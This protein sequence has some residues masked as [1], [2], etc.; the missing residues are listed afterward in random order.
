MQLLFLVTNDLTYDQRM[1]RICSTLADAGYEVQLIGRILPKSKPLARASFAQYRLR[2]FFNKGKLFYIEYNLR[3]FWY[4]LF[5]RF[6]LV[7]AV[8]LDTILPAYWLAK[9]RQKKIVYDAHEYFTEVPEV[10]HRPLTKRIWELVAQWTIPNIKHCYTVGE[11]LARLLSER[12][13][14]DFVVIRNCPKSITPPHHKAA[15]ENSVLLYQGALNMGRGI[16]A[17]IASMQ[18]VE[19]AILWLAGEGDLSEALRDLTKKM[20]VTN[21]V[22]FLGRISP[23]ELKDLTNKATIGLNLLENRGLSYYYSL[24]NKTFDYVQAGVPSINMAFPEYQRLN[25]VYEVSLLIPDLEIK[26]ILVA[27]KTLLH[28][29]KK[30]A[31]L[32][33]NCKK[34]A[35]EWNWEE[36]AKKL[37]DFYRNM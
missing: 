12:Y 18:Y 1:Q 30:Y 22:K 15:I 23:E 25:E 11:G 5:H 13:G 3:L 4:L 20:N 14:V 24:A 21:K 33:N 8:D 31:Q 27:L 26:T 35:Q 2:C 19:D 28:D 9:W 29:K 34:A 32:Q 36:E 10:V 7:C 17:L 6:D 16:E 37:L